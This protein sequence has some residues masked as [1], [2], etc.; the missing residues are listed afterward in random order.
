[1]RRFPANV[2]QGLM[3]TLDLAVGSGMVRGTTNVVHAV[4]IEPR[5]QIMGGCKTIRFR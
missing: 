1:M 4:A 2:L 5:S 3:P